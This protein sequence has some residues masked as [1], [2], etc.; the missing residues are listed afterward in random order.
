MAHEQPAYQI[1]VMSR[2]EISIAIDW[3]RSE[4]WNPGLSDVD[5]FYAADHSGF[6][7]GK[8]D[9]RPVATISA[10]KYG[11]SFGFVGLYIVAEGFRRQGYGIQIWNKALEYLQGRTI[12]LDGVVAQQEN[13]RKSG[14]RLAHR[15]I[16]FAGLAKNVISL[17]A[18]VVELSTVEFDK[19]AAYD[20]HFFPTTRERFLKAWI[21]QPGCCALGILEHAELCGYGVI[22]PCHA[23]Y[24]IGPLNAESR[25]LAATLFDAL[26]ARVP[27]GTAI[28]L[29]TPEPNVQALEMARSYDMQ[30][31]FETARMYIGS[32]P[33]LALHKIFGITSFELG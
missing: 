8:I 1:A 22:R 30:P 27:V 10:V 23:G 20:S 32:C 15:N 28:Y 14:F 7:V 29:D 16:R 11:E 4:G 3:A 5:C 25:D 33:D 21:D 9:G 2:N 18:N 6:L 12:G 24:K 31:S 13:Y 19:L 26:V 17:S